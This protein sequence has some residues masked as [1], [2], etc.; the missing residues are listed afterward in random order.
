MGHSP[1]GNVVVFCFRGDK[2]KT[3]VK[4]TKDQNRHNNEKDVKNLIQRRRK[5]YK[6]RCV[7]RD[8]R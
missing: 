4:V 2:K 7:N 5:D 6:L 8:S 3:K 1:Q